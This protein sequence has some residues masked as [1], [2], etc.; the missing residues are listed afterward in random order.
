MN[1]KMSR[2]NAFI[3]KNEDTIFYL[4]ITILVIGVTI[5]AFLYDIHL[6]NQI[7]SVI[8]NPTFIGEVVNKESTTRNLGFGRYNQIMTYRVHIIGEYMDGGEVIHVDRVFEITRR[9]YN[10]LEIG[11]LIYPS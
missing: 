5:A 10:M 9:W 4:C 7:S 3:D 6:D 1:E 11:D 8:D 2:V